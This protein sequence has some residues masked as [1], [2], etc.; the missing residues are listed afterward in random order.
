MTSAHDP[1]VTPAPSG[2]PPAPSTGA[3]TAAWD[4]GLL[5]TVP[6]YAPGPVLL[7]EVCRA[8]RGLAPTALATRRGEPGDAVVFPVPPDVAHS[9]MTAGWLAVADP[10]GAPVAAARVTGA[11]A[12]EDGTFCLEGH[13]VAT[14]PQERPDLTGRVVVPTADPLDRAQIAAALSVHGPITL[15]ALEGP[16]ADGGPPPAVTRRGL[17]ASAR[18][19]AGELHRDVDVVAVPSPRYGDYRDSEWGLRIA[20]ACGAR[21]VV[22]PDRPS[23]AAAGPEVLAA[24][25]FAY[26][27]GS[28]QWVLA[29]AGE[30]V[31]RAP[32]GPARAGMLAEGDAPAW[33]WPP[34]SV[35][36]LTAW[37]PPRHRRGLVVL[38][39]GLSGSGKSTLARAFVSAIEEEGART[40]TLL[41]GDVV[42]RMLSAGLGFSRADRDLN[43]LRIG[44]VAAQIARHGGLAVA[45]PIAPFRDTR[46]EVRRMVEEHGDLVV[47][48]ISTPL[49]EC[50]RRD[51]KGLY[52]RARAGEIP[53]FTG[54]S[55]PYEPPEDAA[56]AVDTTSI[57]VADGAARVLDVLRRGGWLTPQEPARSPR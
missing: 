57:S 29:A 27:T 28:G 55:S 31:R 6:S 14:A 25:D 56:L 8:V 19:L 21:A 44:F 22:L 48:H 42:R 26:D 24:S 18:R 13:L 37:R 43:V 4:H 2:G 45:A 15:L 9:A 5:A 52:A 54:I 7:A 35:D 30:Q 1:T 3:G 40:V 49:E 39:T 20:T 47:V 32:A 16:R 53:D 51:R 46:D 11:N 23:S 10:E 17:R 36:A 41:D 12:G 34:E 50:E 38:F 33:L